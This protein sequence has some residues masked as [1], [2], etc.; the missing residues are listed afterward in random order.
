M[1]SFYICSSIYISNVYRIFL[2]ISVFNGFNFP[3]FATVSVL[4]VVYYF[5]DMQAEKYEKTKI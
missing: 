3:I 2:L 1:D 5:L 4:N